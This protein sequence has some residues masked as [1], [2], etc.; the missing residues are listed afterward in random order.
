MG[1][2]NLVTPH[3]KQ[4][5]ALPLKRID[6]STGSSPRAIEAIA[7]IAAFLRFERSS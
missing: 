6:T 2:P 5:T 1:R 7:A 3:D 4:A